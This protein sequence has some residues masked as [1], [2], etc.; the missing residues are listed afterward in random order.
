MEVQQLADILLQWGPAGAAAVLILIAEKK[1]RSRWDTAKGKDR[2][3][4]SW[5]Y[6][7]NWVF[8][9]LL[10]TILSTVWVIDRNKATITMSG[11][12]QDLRPSYRVN[13]PTKELFT[14]IQLKNNWLQDVHWHYSKTRLPSNIEI[15]L[16]NKNDFNDYSIPLDM[17]DDIL[18]IHI[19][20]KREKLWLK[21]KSGLYELESV[22]SASSELKP[23]AF[24]NKN[25]ILFPLI[26][27]ANANELVDI[28][29]VFDALES[30]DSYLRQ[31]ASQYL[32]ENINSSILIIEKKLLSSESSEAMLIGLVSALARASSQEL[33]S[34]RKWELSDKAERKVFSLIFSENHILATQSRRYLIRNIDEKYLEL[35]DYKCDYANNAMQRDKEYCSHVALNLIYNLAIKKWGESRGNSPESAIE[36]IEDGLNILDNGLNLGQHASKE[37]SIQFGKIFYG[38]AFLSHE[39]SKVQDESDSSDSINN[40]ITYFQMLLTYIDDEHSGEYEYPHHIRQAKCYIE[41]STQKCFDDFPPE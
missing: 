22:H 21:T 40:A 31:H 14:K 2:T 15:R 20:F 27:V 19:I 11:I 10:L 38:K 6:A 26:S 28:N 39:L 1:L 36:K 34:E 41:M 35:L 30:E 8:I 4:S 29:L 16:E 18:D 5:L 9:A 32:V 17:V 3:I 37:Q 25:R 12:V 23:T 33:V 24:I 7:G 13:D